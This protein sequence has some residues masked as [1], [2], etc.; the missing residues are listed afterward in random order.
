[1]YSLPEVVF[2]NV[3]AHNNFPVKYN[4]AG[5]VLVSGCS[6]SIFENL[7]S[8]KN[9]TPYAMMLDILNSDRYASVVV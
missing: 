7:L 1:G 4:E 3:N 2:W 5:V 6:P 8:G 9:M